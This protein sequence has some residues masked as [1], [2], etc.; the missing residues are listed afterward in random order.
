M[1][2]FAHARRTMVDCQIRPNDVTEARVIDAF[3]D[4]PREPFVP[5]ATQA[6]SYVDTDIPLGQP[7]TRRYLIQPMFLAKLVQAVGV[8]PTDS[9]LD[10]GAGTGYSAAILSQLGAKVV[11]LESDEAL[12]G[13]ARTALAGYGNVSVVTGALE[14]GA[15]SS[16][17]YDVIVLEGSVEEIPAVVFQSLR[18][19][20]RLIAVVGKGRAGRA[21]L[22][23]RVG[24]DFAGRIA[25]DAFL[26]ALPGFDKAPA[27]TF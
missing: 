22:F 14:K 8:K 19:G 11:A 3:L 15:P 5:V 12:A 27:F 2:D 25:F 18:E 1:T 24:N 16:G 26:P 13:A 4:V 17:P 7:G 6:L 23:V 21:T 9:V 10:I 20:G